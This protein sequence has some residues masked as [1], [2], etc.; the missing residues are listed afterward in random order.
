MLGALL[1]E[2]LHRRILRDV[3]ASIPDNPMKSMVEAT[4]KKVVSSI[5]RAG[6]GS[7][8]KAAETAMSSV[9][10]TLED[11]AGKALGPILELEPKMIAKVQDLIGSKIEGP[12]KSAVG[13]KAAKVFEVVLGPLG[14]IYAGA[15]A[16]FKA[17]VPETALKELAG[18]KGEHEAYLA[19][20]WGMWSHSSGIMSAGGVW[21]VVD[22]I[23]A[24]EGLNALGAILAGQTAS[25]IAFDASYDAAALLE[26]ALFDFKMSC[27]TGDGQAA[28]TATL[29]KLA[30]DAKIHA[31][32][33][34]L[35]LLGSIIAVP[36]SEIV[37]P[38][39]EEGLE[40][41]QE[42]VPEALSDLINIPR[43]AI[44]VIDGVRDDALKAL[45][46]PALVNELAKIDA[47]A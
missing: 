41:V 42:L 30:N 28:Y 22:T 31:E 1:N 26:K 4:V 44:T 27:A 29:A 19:A 12:I 11:A 39:I 33:F 15:V 24:S 25:S 43:V 40:P 32:V 17:H 6:A 14:S 13:E 37:N 5:V 9:S 18:G 20:R 36:I 7:A 8:W 45:V 46:T 35:K 34:S 16:G 38:M 10:K 2:V 3:Y 23:S 21:K 47:A